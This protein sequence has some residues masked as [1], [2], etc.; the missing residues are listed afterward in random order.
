MLYLFMNIYVLFKKIHMK[1]L[2]QITSNIGKWT[3]GIF[4]NLKYLRSIS[5]DQLAKDEAKKY[6]K[7]F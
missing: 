7:I 1:N 5:K 4:N 6:L 2:S 3:S